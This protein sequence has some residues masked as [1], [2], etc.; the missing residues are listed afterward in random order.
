[1][2]RPPG[3]ADGEI[4]SHNLRPDALAAWRARLLMSAGFGD[5]LAHQLA[6]TAGVDVH[7][8][9]NLVDRGCPPR[10]AAR[11][12]APAAERRE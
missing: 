7:E 4:T 11:I 10:L 12:L 5:R 6:G 1:M 8:L 3:P 2:P 9:L